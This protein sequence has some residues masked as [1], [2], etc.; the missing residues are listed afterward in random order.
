M[1]RV[2]IERNR[3]RVGFFEGIVERNRSSCSLRSRNLKKILFTK[4]S[5]IDYNRSF[6]A[7]SSVN[8]QG[9]YQPRIARIGHG[10]V[11][12]DELLL[13]LVVKS[14]LSK[15]KTREM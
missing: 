8:E 9:I 11:G 6:V 13:P 14:K 5:A 2:C 3:A 7:E 4:C 12:D 1:Y 15:L 10:N